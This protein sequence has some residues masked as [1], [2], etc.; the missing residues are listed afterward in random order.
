MDVLTVFAFTVLPSLAQLP[1]FKP[2][3]NLFSKEQDVQL[4]KEAAGEVEKQVE[5]VDNKELNAYINLIGSKLAA[6]P[7]IAGRFLAGEAEPA[8]RT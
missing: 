8:G 2:G 4:G 3:F 5:L 7:V 6:G 1:Q